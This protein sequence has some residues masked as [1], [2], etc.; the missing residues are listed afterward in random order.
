[1]TKLSALPSPSSSLCESDKMV[2]PDGLSANVGI[3]EMLIVRAIE[4][5]AHDFLKLSTILSMLQLSDCDVE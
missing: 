3:V 1:M 2:C 5:K 4:I